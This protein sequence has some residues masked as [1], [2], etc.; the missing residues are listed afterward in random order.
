MLLLRGEFTMDEA[1]TIDLNSD[2]AVREFVSDYARNIQGVATTSLAHFIC[3]RLQSINIS[4][5]GNHDKVSLDELCRTAVD[6]LLSNNDLTQPRLDKARLMYSQEVSRWRCVQSIDDLNKDI[7]CQREICVRSQRILVVHMWHN[8]EMLASQP[9]LVIRSPINRTAMMMQMTSAIEKLASWRLTIAKMHSE[10]A[11]LEAAVY[12][13]L[14]WAVETK[15]QLVEVFNRFTKAVNL[16]KKHY[17]SADHLS[18]VIV[19]NCSAILTFE[20]LRFGSAETLDSDQQF[21]DLVSAWEKSCNLMASCAGVVTPVEQALMELLDPE[22]P[23]DLAWLNS[24]VA[25]IAELCDQEH[26]N[27]V[28]N[29]RAIALTSEKLTK[30]SEQLRGQMSVHQRLAIHVKGLVRKLLKT[31]TEGVKPMKEFLHQHTEF[32]DR[33]IALFNRM[34]LFEN[35]VEEINHKIEQIDELLKV[36]PLVFDGLFSLQPSETNLPDIHNTNESFVQ[37]NPSERKSY[38]TL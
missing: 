23:L 14:N 18:D 27:L 30:C 11:I 13:H 4:H 9:G 1:T 22:G 25:I 38:L 5:D 36:Q 20:R 10:A 31:D 35:D 26:D 17:D 28:S 7:H 34:K 33:V 37:T 16:K 15:P 24:V 32:V 3:H 21:F 2:L 19:A 12:Q 6:T 29:K 8:E